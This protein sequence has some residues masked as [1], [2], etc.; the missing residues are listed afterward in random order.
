V[1]INQRRRDVFQFVERH[2]KPKDQEHPH[3]QDPDQ[4]QQELPN[5]KG[6]R[7]VEK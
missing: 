3:Q 5:P 6:Y 2:E 1:P 4:R 7:Q